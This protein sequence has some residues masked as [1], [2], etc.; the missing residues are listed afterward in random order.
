ML[1]KG[2]SNTFKLKK[3]VNKVCVPRSGTYTIYP[4]SCYSFAEAT[5]NIK[6]SSDSSSITNIVVAGVRIEGAVD[7]IS[8]NALPTVTLSGID[9]KSDV[10]SKVDASGNFGLMAP[11]GIQNVLLTVSSDNEAYIINPSEGIK[12]NIPKSGCPKI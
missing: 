1:I 8:G 11:Q 6:T 10:S 3:G 4:S 5:Y 12:F 7:G 9:G 2:E